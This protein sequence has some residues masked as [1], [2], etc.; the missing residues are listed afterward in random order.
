MLR[1]LRTKWS[2]YFLVMITALLLTVPLEA[3][4]KKSQ[5]SAREKKAQES[6]KEKKAQE[7]AKENKLPEPTTEKKTSEPATE[8]DSRPASLLSPDIQRILDRGTLVVAT[9][10]KDTPP[11]FMQD[12]QGEMQGF[13]VELIR[14]FAKRLGVKVVF[15][16]DS[17]SFDGVVD[18]V[19]RGVVD[20]GVSKLSCTFPRATKVRFTQPY[21]VLRQGLLVNRLALSRQSRGRSAQDTIKNLTGKLG[22]IRASSYVGFAR[23]RFGKAEIVDFPSWNEVVAAATKGEVVAAYRDELEVKKVVYDHPET[24]LNLETVVLLDAKDPI[25]MAV[26]WHSEHLLSLLNMFLAESDIKLTAD[27]LLERYHKR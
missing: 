24:A 12:A 11:F 17:T 23:E 5:E 26:A 21:V 13:E 4:E 2:V 22:V 1:W 27:T 16:R 9:Y 6:A 19:A 20:V 7:S 14:N 3:K 8:K 10:F 25:A 15:N 18:S